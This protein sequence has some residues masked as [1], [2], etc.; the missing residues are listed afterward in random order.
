[1]CLL[2][3]VIFLPTLLTNLRIYDMYDTYDKLYSGMNL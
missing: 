1:M 3:T 2:T